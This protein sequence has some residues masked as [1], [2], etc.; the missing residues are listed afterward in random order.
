MTARLTSKDKKFYL[1]VCFTL[2]IMFGF[3]YLP[4]IA[5]IT[6]DGMRILGIF[7]GCLFA[8]VFGEIV[9]SSILGVV[10]TSAYGMG[11]M[12]TNFASAFANPS[13]AIT[14]TSLVFCYAIEKSG[15]LSEIAHWIVGV[16]WAQKSPFLLILAFFVASAI[17]AIMICN[18]VPPM[19]LL[20]ALYYELAKEID[21]KPFEAFSNIVLCG[22][23]VS[24]AMGCAVMPYSG[25]AAIV[26]GIAQQ[27]DPA[28]IFNTA[29]YIILNFAVMLLFFIMVM[30]VL[31]LFFNKQI[32]KITIP[33]REAYKLNLNTESKIA[34]T[35]LFLVVAFM[36][37]PNFMPADNEFRVLINTQLAV[38]GLFMIGSVVLMLI[39]VKGEPVLDIVQGL[40]HVPWP[41]FLLVAAA[42]CMSD[43]LI[44]DEMGVKATFIDLF[45]PLVEGKSAFAITM[46]FVALGLIM[47]NFI[48][49]MATVSILAPIALGFIVEQNDS[50]AL[51]TLLFAQAVVQGCLMPSGSIVGAMLHGNIGWL[52]SKDIILYVG[53]MELIV[54]ADLL[55]VTFIGGKVGI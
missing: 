50:I 33:S 36:I 39:H 23:G 14:I 42:L 27:L 28:F 49:D 51:F 5:Q 45:N 6:P 53:L 17:L 22:I 25:M 30:I 11:T 15:L 29:E 10:L 46:I 38:P 2:V 16:K 47:T 26:R 20:W 21:A 3:G 44:A 8:W 24:A 35:V 4:P 9:W 32:K 54:L 52:K 34:L 31:C 18:F 1:V 13:I 48:N 19:V 12:A 43:Y 40:A 7:L 37:F 41:L 55:L